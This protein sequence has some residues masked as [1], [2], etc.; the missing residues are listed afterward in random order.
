MES[1]V[2]CAIYIILILRGKASVISISKLQ[3]LQMQVNSDLEVDIKTI[4]NKYILFYQV[5]GGETCCLPFGYV[6]SVFDFW[7]GWIVDQTS[8]LG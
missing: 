4:S 2:W 3:G 6:I 8:E 1:R 5:T 7:G